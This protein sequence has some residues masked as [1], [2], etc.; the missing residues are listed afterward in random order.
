ML[1]ASIPASEKL[2]LIRPSIKP[3][4]FFLLRCNFTDPPKDK[5]LL[6]V[7]DNPKPLF[8]MV[9]S[10]IHT[11]IKDREHLLGG[12]FQIEKKDYKFLS[13]DSFLNCTNPVHIDIENIEKQLL[14]DMGRIKD[15][16]TEIDRKLIWDIVKESETLSPNQI[17]WIKEEFSSGVKVKTL[18][19][20]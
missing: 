10:K 11:Y 15:K 17:K 6:L 13:Y 1:R 18:S 8:F 9:N 12:Q 16:I 5:F 7:S 3:G 2:K 4:Q 14:Q 19:A 20:E